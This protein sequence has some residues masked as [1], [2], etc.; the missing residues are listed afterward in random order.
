MPC[1]HGPCS[2][3]FQTSRFPLLYHSIWE[4]LVTCSY[5]H[6]KFL[7]FFFFLAVLGLHCGT[8]F[9][10]CDVWASL[11]V[12][13]GF[14]SCGQA[15]LPCGMWDL[16]F[17]TRDQTHVFCIAK[18]VLNHWI[19]R[20]FLS[21]FNSLKLNKTMVPQSHQRQFSVLNSC[22]WLVAIMLESADKGPF[23]CQSKFQLT[24]LLTPHGLS[25]QLQG[26]QAS[27]QKSGCRKGKQKMV[28]G[29][30]CPECFKPLLSIPLV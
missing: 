2:R 21:K 30:L 15:Q 18:Q 23:Q 29:T 25:T 6:F 12:A 10:C 13:L 4:P 20:K 5:L 28:L 27:L 11:V 1:K 14:F 24:M 16:S 9:L 26:F 22:V 8:R 19:T 3:I 7:F 17:L